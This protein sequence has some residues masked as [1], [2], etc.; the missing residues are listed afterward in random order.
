MSS[1]NCWH[2]QNLTSSLESKKYWLNKQIVRKITN[3]IL[4]FTGRQIWPD[5]QVQGLFCQAHHLQPIILLKIPWVQILGN[6]VQHCS[7][8]DAVPTEF[9][10]EHYFEST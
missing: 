4:L 3:K 2:S 9:L 1:V 8:R 6:W 10:V 5:G 7:Q